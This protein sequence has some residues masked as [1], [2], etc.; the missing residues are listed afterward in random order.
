MS[1]NLLKTF[2]SSKLG[3]YLQYEG[4]DISVSDGKISSSTIDL[5]NLIKFVLNWLLNGLEQHED[6]VPLH[7]LINIVDWVLSVDFALA[8]STLAGCH[9]QV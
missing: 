9:A 8:L 4:Q 5:M 1:T 3:R 7:D 2:K 6:V